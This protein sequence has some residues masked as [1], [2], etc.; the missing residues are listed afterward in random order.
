MSLCPLLRDRIYTHGEKP[1]VH[2][3]NRVKEYDFTDVL[4]LL[5]ITVFFVFAI[6]SFYPQLSLCPGLDIVR[7]FTSS[8]LLALAP[9]AYSSSYLWFHTTWANVYELSSPSMEVFQTSLAYLSVMVIF[10]F[11]AMAKA[12]LKDV[13]RCA[14]I[15]A[16]VC[17][18]VFA[19]FGWLYFLQE[20][21]VAT[22]L[23]AYYSFLSEAHDRSYFDVG[24]AQGWIWFWFRP[25]T[26]GLTLLFILLY[27]LREHKLS[28]GAFML[29]FTLIL[30]TLNFVHFS[31]SIVFVLFLLVLSSLKPMK[32]LRIDEAATSSALAM[33]A[34]LPLIFTYQNI[35]GTLIIEPPPSHL[36][37]LTA[38]SILSILLARLKKRPDVKS[39]SVI[40]WLITGAALI[41]MWLLITWLFTAKTFAV[42]SVTA[43]YGVPWQFYP[44]LLGLSGL[45]AICSSLIIIKRYSKHPVT[46]FL[47]L[48]LFAVLFG[49]A[50]TYYNLNVSDSSYWERR[51]IPIAYAASAVTAPISIIELFKHIQKY[52]T[53]VLTAFLS[54]L[55]IFGVSSTFLA[56]ELQTYNAKN[57]AL[58]DASLTLVN[59]LNKLGP[60]KVLLTATDYS[61]LIAEFVPFSWNIDKYR[62][63]LWSAKYPELPLSVLYS[64]NKPVT[65]FLREADIREINK[66]YASSYLFNHLMSYSSSNNLA[67]LA[68]ILSLPNMT[69]PSSN[70]QTVLVLPDY[71]DPIT[72]HGYDMLSQARFNYTTAL[73]DDINTVSK[74]RTLIAPTESIALKLISYREL[75][76]LEFENLVILNLDGY[77]DLSLKYFSNKMTLSLDS[78][79]KKVA[80]L[81]VGGAVVE[82]IMG[83]GA[84]IEFEVHST[85]EHGSFYG[86]LDENF[87]GW[88]TGGIG[89]GNISSPQLTL[90]DSAR[91]SGDSSIQIGVTSG[92]FGYWQISKDFTTAINA[93]N[94][95]FISFYWYGRGD[96]KNYALNF[97]SNPQSNY[98]YYFKDSWNGWKKVLIPMHTPDGRYNLNDVYFVKVTNGEPAWNNIRRI[99]IRNEGSNPNVA[100]TFLIDKF[101]FESAETINV[102]IATD[103]SFHGFK[104]LNH[105]GTNW[106]NIAELTSN[107]TISV[108]NYTLMSGL[109]SNAIFG[110]KS[111]LKINMTKN[112]DYSMSTISVK[113]PPYV[114]D[115]NFSS[116]Q[117]KIIPIIPDVEVDE[118]TGPNSSLQL[119]TKISVAPLETRNSV[120]AWYKNKEKSVPFAIKDDANEFKIIY[121]NIY[122]LTTSLVSDKS[123]Y[124]PLGQ[125]AH[126]LNLNQLINK[127]QITAENPV[128]GNLATF[129][130]IDFEGNITIHSTA[131]VIIKK[132]NNTLTLTLPNITLTGLSK[133]IFI[134]DKIIL[135]AKKGSLNNG[136]GFYSNIYSDNLIVISATGTA[137]TIILEFNNGTKQTINEPI[138]NIRIDGNSV[139]TLRQ[140]TL[141]IDGKITFCNLYTYAS[142]SYLAIFG[143]GAL[144]HGRLSFNVNF[145]DEFTVT[146]NFAYTGKLTT[147]GYRYDELNVLYQSLPIFLVTGLLFIA[148]YALAL[149]TIKKPGPN[150][151]DK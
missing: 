140:P 60:D 26:L 56:L 84:P 33:L 99:E 3:E 144:L 12:Y 134:G 132:M 49:R 51:I 53:V 124:E 37:L 118:I 31:E 146:T 77:T 110:R 40:Q 10:S 115:T 109:N 148:A 14:P 43:V 5:W 71:Q 15:L 107:E 143:K 67:S 113:L 7:H 75:F 24:Y 64:M 122:P 79:S 19:G 136:M 11:Y 29:T 74:A 97:H 20:R 129:S 130:K 96:G 70:S 120:I 106:V 81:N 91:V 36:I 98:W 78:I 61:R 119:N 57:Y 41:Y 131:T 82:N 48:L 42:A 65:V 63:Q 30:L 151:T 121:V 55:V 6:S 23:S 9:E 92:A 18:S 83:I 46:V 66:N 76:K 111:F 62:Y 133:I 22:D 72:W 116:I 104:L 52:K 34:S 137:E 45:F 16:T 85:Y 89:F 117:L 47:L 101:G 147:D 94:F 102:T 112:S 50:L 87:E 100:G 38:A 58:S 105:N 28:K 86:L 44:M 80:T 88:M 4:L 73:V 149:L 17:F 69:A 90:N 145:G 2:L 93:D 8:R 68:E 25:L 35:V 59:V 128:R 95:D 103:A 32:E 108:S 21:I 139:A 123:N 114:S 54:F 127:A 126:I 150:G 135:N 27:L 142:L 141:Q 138:H 1:Q 13:E 125:I 39:W